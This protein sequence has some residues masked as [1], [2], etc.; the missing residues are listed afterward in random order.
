MHYI[1]LPDVPET[2]EVVAISAREWRVSDPRKIER[3]G[4]ALVGFVELVGETYEAT[5][6]G[7]PTHRKQCLS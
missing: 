2:A 1:N 7:D 6:L 4:L 3:D 5:S